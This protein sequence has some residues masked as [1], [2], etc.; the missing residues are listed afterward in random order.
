LACLD[1]PDRYPDIAR[2]MAN[3]VTVEAHLE[4]VRR[5][6]LQYHDCI[7][8]TEVPY[9]TGWDQLTSIQSSKKRWG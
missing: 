6:V 1:E 4:A 5:Q 9:I 2:G 8:Q 7:E 3:R